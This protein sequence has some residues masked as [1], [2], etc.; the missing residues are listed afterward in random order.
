[1]LAPPAT[2]PFLRRAR[3]LGRV[4]L[5]LAALPAA[6]A[7]IYASRGAYFTT[8][9]AA[10]LVVGVVI[11]AAITAVLAYTVL[12]HATLGRRARTWALTAIVPVALATAMAVLAEPR[13]HHRRRG[14][15]V[16]WHSR[17]H[18]PP[19]RGPG[20]GRLCASRVNAHSRQLP[21]LYP[22]PMLPSAAGL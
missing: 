10:G 17:I 13:I 12:W 21:Q 6:A 14:S 19:R 4:K 15:P 2:E 5:S 20:A 16:S 22:D 11:A 8:G 3:M 18:S 7:A 9:R 1:M